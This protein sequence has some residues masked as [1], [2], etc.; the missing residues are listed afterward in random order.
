MKVI[1]GVLVPIEGYKSVGNATI[2]FSDGSLE[3][4]STAEFDE[5]QIVGSGEITREPCKQISLRR[6]RF[7]DHD[8]TIFT[9]QGSTVNL[10]LGDSFVYD[11][12]GKLTGIKVDW[13]ATPKSS[14]NDKEAEIQEISVL[15]IGDT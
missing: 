4:G 5:M 11:S 15:I 9:F 6:I 7:E 8:D 10:N 2:N 13:L 12:S 14:G 1:S 3:S